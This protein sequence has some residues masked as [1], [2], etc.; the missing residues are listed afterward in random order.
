MCSTLNVSLSLLQ[1]HTLTCTHRHTH[2]QSRAA[3]GART[4]AA[5][6]ACQITTGVTHGQKTW[7]K[8]L[9]GSS[10]PLKVTLIYSLC[11]GNTSLCGL[12]EVVPL[13]WALGDVWSRYRTQS[14]LSS[15]SAEAHGTRGRG[16][17]IFRLSFL[18]QFLFR[19]MWVFW[20]RLDPLERIQTQDKA[21]FSDFERF[22]FSMLA[23]TALYAAKKRKKP[24]QKM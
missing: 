23:N 24:V 7:T 11:C 21:T 15:R 13:C 10:K 4:A 17:R 5:A 22:E 6:A 1:A 14:T 9:R 19:G 8:L 16:G 3:S 20:A 12:W 18:F 2:T